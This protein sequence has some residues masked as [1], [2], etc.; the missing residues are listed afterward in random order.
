MYPHGA[1]NILAE[2]EN[3]GALSFTPGGNQY[4]FQRLHFKNLDPNSVRSEVKLVKGTLTGTPS[5]LP[6]GPSVNPYYL[7][8]KVLLAYTKCNLTNTDDRLV[9]ISA[10]A[11]QVR[12]MTNDRYLAG[13]WRQHLEYHLLWYTDPRQR[14]RLRT[15]EYVAPSWSWASMTA[16]IEP[17]IFI[18]PDI[19]TMI[20]IIDARVTHSTSDAMGQVS[21]GY[22]H[23][24]GWLK[25]FPIVRVKQRGRLGLA[26]F[27]SPQVADTVQLD[28]PLPPT[29]QEAYF[30]P[31]ALV[32]NRLSQHALGLILLGTG[33]KDEFKR[34][35]RFFAQ[36]DMSSTFR[37]PAYPLHTSALTIRQKEKRSGW[38]GK[39]KTMDDRYNW[40]ERVFNII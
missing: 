30:L 25:T 33:R 38:W 19:P 21:A 2:P 22:L 39:T 4:G 12:D 31:I 14:D 20:Q 15:P 27:P 8:N 17:Y 34:V 18:R 28:V 29:I 6:S 3:K 24:R 32:G 5:E 1:P 16:R 11:K 9:A 10:V 35:G 37:R 26:D 36:D 13:M 7:W 23:I 40:T